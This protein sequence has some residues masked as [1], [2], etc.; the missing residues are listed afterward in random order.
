MKR[1][2]SGSAPFELSFRADPEIPLRIEVTG[3]DVHFVRLLG[4]RLAGPLFNLEPV[5]AEWDSCPER[6]A[7]RVGPSR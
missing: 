5:V 4:D 7:Q 2:A 3:V 6:R 1:A